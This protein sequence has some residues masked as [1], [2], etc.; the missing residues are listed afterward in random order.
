MSFS[1]L[2]QGFESDQKN[3][4]H[5]YQRNAQF[6]DVSVSF[7][8]PQAR[9]AAQQ[10]SA[11]QTQAAPKSLV[12]S[13]AIGYKKDRTGPSASLGKI[14]SCVLADKTSTGGA[15]AGYSLVCYDLQTRDVLLSHAI[16]SSSIFH[17][18]QKNFLSFYDANGV[19]WSLRFPNENVQQSFLQTLEMS[20]V[21]EPNTQHQ[22]IIST[23]VPGN[24]TSNSSNGGSGAT[25]AS[26][27]SNHPKTYGP[28]LWSFQGLDITLDDHAVQEPIT[29]DVVNRL[30]KV[31]RQ[32]LTQCD[33]G[34]RR[35][36][37][38]PPH[39]AFGDGYY[40]DRTR[41]TVPPN[42]TIIIELDVRAI[43]APSFRSSS[44][45]PPKGANESN[46]PILGVGIT[47][48]TTT[49]TAATAATVPIIGGTMTSAA[50]VD[51]TRRGEEE[52]LLVPMGP[53]GNA[54]QGD[55]H[56]KDVLR[57][58]ARLSDNRGSLLTKVLGIGGGDA[59]IDEKDLRKDD[60]ND[61]SGDSS[62]DDAAETRRECLSSTSSANTT[63]NGTSREHEYDGQALSEEGARNVLMMTRARGGDEFKT[64]ADGNTNNTSS[65][66]ATITTTTTTITNGNNNSSNKALATMSEE[67]SE[68]SVAD[69]AHVRTHW[70]GLEKKLESVEQKID[71]IIRLHPA[72]VK[73]SGLSAND[74]ISCLQT[75]HQQ[76]EGNQ[77]TIREL[78]ERLQNLQAKNVQLLEKNQILMEFKLNSMTDSAV[79][80]EK[81]MREKQIEQLKQELKAKGQ[82]VD[83][84]K[85]EI[86]TKDAKLDD[87]KAEIQTKDA[88][89]EQLQSEHQAKDSK[90]K[91]LGLES[92]GKD[93]KMEELLLKI[94]SQDK[95]IQQLQLDH[96]ETEKTQMSE[97]IQRLRSEQHQLS[98]EK[99]QLL[100]ERQQLLDQKQQLSDEKQQL[101]N[102]K[103]QLLDQ[104][105]QVIKENA[106]LTA[107]HEQFA[108]ELK[109]FKKNYQAKMKLKFEESTNETIKKLM[110]YVYTHLDTDNKQLK[111]EL[112]RISKA[113][114]SNPQIIFQEE[115]NVRQ[116]DNAP[117]P[118]TE[119]QSAVQTESKSES[120]N[121]GQD[122][123]PDNTQNEKSEP[124]NPEQDT[125]PNNT[126]NE[127]PN[128]N[129]SENET[130][131]VDRLTNE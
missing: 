92:A 83:D 85:V 105:D 125:A 41:I 2:T 21:V 11:V 104:K 87:L 77:Q 39:L 4:K 48:A 14:G 99:K 42:A 71:E 90:L 34:M 62:D 73:T 81:E 7:S 20:K 129:Q 24:E 117:P 128:T 131:A 51:N 102:E 13:V 108:D 119:S 18:Q 84:L 107:A 100:D 23:L 130:E 94:Q 37:I 95:T 46:K 101:S 111:S 38:C 113:I 74:V 56:K 96:L 86:Q 49:T 40:D 43:K 112:R 115:E 109:Q 124:L 55:D 65:N 69:Y 16:T 47:T 44:P 98:E 1:K 93:Q 45:F 5:L 6:D 10:A 22:L 19:Y 32:A 57:R 120:S 61:V 26:N 89:L 88:K 78:N 63:I 33:V 28:R 9:P 68:G 91:E 123:V 59:T 52:H 25:I 12:A 60:P 17:A 126:Q 27:N 30:K 66:N 80:S 53:G 50:T 70:T 36:V 122:T 58:M 106:E 127:E 97:D 8:T 116:D 121:P 29:V 35:L 82:Q 103:Q 67:V 118:S 114:L 110:D 31:I 72:N 15:K 3:L 75:L 76:N 79:L 64:T 54:P